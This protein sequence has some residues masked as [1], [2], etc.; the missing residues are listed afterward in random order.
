MS[1]A[2]THGISQAVSG[3]KITHSEC[4]DSRG[5]MNTNTVQKLPAVQ[6]IILGSYKKKK[7]SVLWSAAV[8]GQH[9]LL[10]H[11]HAQKKGGEKCTS[12]RSLV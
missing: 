6:E 11:F 7:R 8:R 12:V 2:K 4:S 1:P 10:G 5:D 3:S 9:L